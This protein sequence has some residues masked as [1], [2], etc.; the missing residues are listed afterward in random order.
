MTEYTLKIANAYVS[1]QKLRHNATQIKQHCGNQV[2]LCAV[3]KADGY[4]HSGALVVT[5]LVD[6][7]DYFAVATIEEA[8]QIYPFAEG[9]PILVMCP[10]F[11]GMDAGLIRL[12]QSRGFHCTIS[13]P[14]GLQYTSDSLIENEPRLHIHLKIDTGMGRIGC[15]VAEGTKILDTIKHQEKYLLKGVYTHLATANEED[16]KFANEQLKVFENFLQDSKLNNNSSV[17]KHV[18]NTAG[19][20][21]IPKGHFDMVRCG[22]GIY[23]YS[24]YQDKPEEMPDLQP[25]LQLQ[26]PLIL[27][28]SLKAGQSCGYGRTFV[29]PKDM[30]M[31]IVP[32]GYADGLFRNLSNQAKLRCGDQFIPIVGRISMDC[33]IVD[34]TGVK[35]PSEGMTVTV[36]DDHTDS[37]CNAAGL[38][39]SA[40]TIPYEIL[41][42]IG[43]R[44]RRELVD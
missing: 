3:V 4:G 14:A 30:I 27:V 41:T 13:S 40:G 1:R 18:C 38:A 25:A 33:T 16:L 32:I 7:V 22:I 35:D 23:G 5:S 6:L 34:L 8:A 28:K 29:A 44:V 43:S 42:A 37:C 31:G 24:T 20:L 21:R 9:K 15:S 17:I 2:K 39:E 19:T 12:A 10:L 11:A 26:A 36:I